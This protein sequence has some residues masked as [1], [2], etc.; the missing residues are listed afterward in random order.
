[1]SDRLCW[2]RGSPE[3]LFLQFAAFHERLWRA[4]LPAPRRPIMSTA[5]RRQP[6]PKP[7]RIDPITTS[8]IQGALENIA[9]EMG[10]K[11]MRMSYSSIIREIGG[12]RRGSGRRRG[13]RPRRIGAVDAAAV[14]ADPGLHP[15]HPEDAEGARRGDPPRRRHHA[16][17][18][19]FRRQPRPRRRLRRAGVRR[20]P[21]DRL[22]GNNGP[23]SRH[24]RAVARVLRHRRGDRRL[25]RR[26]A[27]QGDQGLRPRREERRRLAD[28]ARQHPR[29]RPRGRRHGCPGR[30]PPG[31]APIAWSSWS[32]ATASRPSTWPARR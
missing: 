9:I 29:L 5:P 1:M 2:E 20:R 7:D 31:S 28:C 17:R 6:A 30:R 32:S 3:P 26:P 25:C 19:L 10:Y 8:V 16:Q 13:P 11:L 21:P 24:R 4:A 23:S 12:F 14:R 22:C 27:V 15:R 18:R